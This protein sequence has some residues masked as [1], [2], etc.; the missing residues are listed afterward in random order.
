[1]SGIQVCLPSTI[2]YKYHEMIHYYE[3]FPLL[4]LLHETVSVLLHVEQTTLFPYEKEVK[5]DN[6]IP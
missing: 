2:L 4:S 1:M 6:C 5:H 3:H